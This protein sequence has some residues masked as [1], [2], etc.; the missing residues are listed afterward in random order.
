M[1]LNFN[2]QNINN[3]GNDNIT[4]LRINPIRDMKDY[5]I[6]MYDFYKT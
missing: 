5:K 2:S 1:Y 4:L 3:N 6:K